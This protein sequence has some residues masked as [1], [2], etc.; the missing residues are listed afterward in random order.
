MISDNELL[1]LYVIKGEQSAFEKLIKK[2]A[3]MVMHVCRTFLWNPADCDDAF[4]S[5]FVLLSRKSRRLLRHSCL[6]G[7]LHNAAVNISLT[8]RRSIARQRE[9]EF[10]FEPESAGVEPWE[11]I[12]NAQQCEKLHLEI[13]RLP[14]IYRDAIVMCHLNGLS[15]CEAAENLDATTSSVKAALARGRKLLR[16]RLIQQGIGLSTVFAIATKSSGN[17]NAAEQIASLAES[18]Y[19]HVLATN[20]KLVAT[21]SNFIQLISSKGLA[22]M[23][24]GIVHT[25]LAVALGFVS[26]GAIGLGLM[27]SE[28]SHTVA[29]PLVIHQEESHRLDDSIQVANGDDAD[30]NSKLE[31]PANL[32]DPDIAPEIKKERDSI[33]AK[34]QNQLRKLDSALHEQTLRLGKNHPKLK[35]LQAQI[36]LLAQI[37]EMYLDESLLSDLEHNDIGDHPDG[38]MFDE[39]VA[40][41]SLMLLHQKMIEASRLY[42]PEHPTVVK[43]H[44]QIEALKQHQAHGAFQARSTPLDEVNSKLLQLESQLHLAL[45]HFGTGHPKVAALKTELATLNQFRDDYVAEEFNKTKPSQPKLEKLF[46]IKPKQTQA[47]YARPESLEGIF[48]AKTTGHPGFE[49]TDAQG[50]VLRRFLDKNGDKKLDTWIYFKHGIE[51]YR[52]IDRNGDGKVDEVHF[53]ERD[54]VR[55][56]KDPNQDGEIVNWEMKRLSDLRK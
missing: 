42:G 41:K 14:A 44:A 55:I 7:W 35:D 21:K 18:A 27:N 20:T 49:A 56:G 5:V 28:N 48:L 37:K 19:G 6:G 31:L 51:T 8:K 40:A 9:V 26:F 10:E 39:E 50:N 29:Q 46:K 34:L 12:A 24:I 33:L 16:Q 53:T 11:S 15:R 25:S 38:S 43:L 54:S 22:A 52:D 17:L 4:Q 32:G 45:K 1:G 30:S 2:H 13:A 3:P 23:P 47:D 36:S